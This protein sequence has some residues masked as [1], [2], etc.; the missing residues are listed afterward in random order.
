MRPWTAARLS[1]AESSGARFEVAPGQ[2]TTGS[3]KRSA[4]AGTACA[5]PSAWVGMPASTPF[6]RL[7]TDVVPSARFLFSPYPGFNFYSDAC[8]ILSAKS[9]RVFSSGLPSWAGAESFLG[10]EPLGLS[11]TPSGSYVWGMARSEAYSSYRR[12]TRV[13]IFVRTS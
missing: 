11:C 6:Q 10:K 8:T 4:G 7:C 2:F 12:G 1:A 5:W 9:P 3:W 13:L